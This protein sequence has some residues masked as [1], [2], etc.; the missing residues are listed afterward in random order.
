MVNII[1]A[2]ITRHKRH[3][4]AIADPPPKLATSTGLWN[5]SLCYERGV[6]VAQDTVAAQALQQQCR[7]REEHTQTRRSSSS[8]MAGGAA[9][10]AVVASSG[11]PRRSSETP[12]FALT[13]TRDD[14]TV[15]GASERGGGRRRSSSI[16]AVTPP[17]PDGPPPAHAR[18]PDQGQDPRSTADPEKNAAAAAP[19]A[20]SAAGVRGVG[21][22]RG[23]ACEGVHCCVLCRLFRASGSCWP[24]GPSLF[25]LCSHRRVLTRVF[26]VHVFRRF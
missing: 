7:D 23:E 16:P 26:F 20:A 8:S 11:P 3:T 10:P 24:D 22:G 19:A 6:G 1:A 14:G 5:L 18:K 17:P 15:V 12:T 4:L 21:Y 25:V 13:P 2:S 9:A